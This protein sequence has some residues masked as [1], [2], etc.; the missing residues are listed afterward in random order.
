[1]ICVK[2][3]LNAYKMSKYYDNRLDIY[4]KYKCNYHLLLLKYATIL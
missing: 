2:N 3:L 4:I 1:M